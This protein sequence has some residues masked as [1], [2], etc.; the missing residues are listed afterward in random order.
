MQDEAVAKQL[1]QEEEAA[2]PSDE[3]VAR[4]LAE[5]EEVKKVPA[6]QS[7]V[8][9]CLE[10]FQNSAQPHRV[11]KVMTFTIPLADEPDWDRTARHSLTS[12]SDRGLGRSPHRE[13]RHGRA[14]RKIWRQHGVSN[15]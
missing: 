7:R 6:R 4:K 14:R 12:R 13:E 3:E 8:A 9:V 1:Q 15:E 10:L 11:L 5:K 2:R